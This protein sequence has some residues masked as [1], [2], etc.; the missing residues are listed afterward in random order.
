MQR[1]GLGH[2]SRAVDLLISD[3]NDRAEELAVELHATNAERRSIDEGIKQDLIRKIEEDPQ[4]LDKRSMV[5]FDPSWHKGVIGIAASRAVELYHRP[6]IVLTASNGVLTG[7]AR[8]IPGFDIH[9]ALQ[10]CSEHLSQFGGHKFAAGLSLEEDRLEAFTHAFEQ[11]AKAAL[12]DED[13]E[14]RLYY[15]LE[16]EDPDSLDDLLYKSLERMAPFGPSNRQ[17]VFMTRLRPI[18]TAWNR[19]GADGSHLKV[20]FDLGSRRMSAIGFGLG[21]RMDE[22]KKAGHPVEA[23]FQL[24]EN[25]FNGN[26]NLQLLLKD[27]RSTS[28]SGTVPS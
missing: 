8:S 11:A 1:A 9:E 28:D 19:V 10:E 13:L 26:R 27:I 3:N 6:T 18:D 12:S 23:C 15:D 24:N 16:L 25:V 7:S 4:L 17:A 21:D 14:P 22:L 20:D 2:A 5:F